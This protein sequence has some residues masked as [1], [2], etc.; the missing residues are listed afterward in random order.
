MGSDNPIAVPASDSG[1]IDTH[2]VQYAHDFAI[3]RYKYILQ[4]V[5]ATNE[6]VHKF[7]S[8]YQAL[9]T[10]LTGSGIVLFVGY[11]KWE[12]SPEI[13]RMGITGILWLTTFVGAFTC[14]LV[15]IGAL[16]WL[17]YRK[18]ECELTDEF[19]YPGFRRAPRFRNFVRWY[20][21]YVVLFIVGSGVFLWVY[22][23]LVILPTVK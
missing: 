20:E 13:V 15:I 6:N 1:D 12:I 2:P 23:E 5:N 16:A 11:K 14:L 8:M 9:A 4:Q 22:A 17:D 3:E 18:E 19:V 21:T 10:T 7:L